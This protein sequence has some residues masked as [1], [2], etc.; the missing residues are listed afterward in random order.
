MNTF[1]F[2]LIQGARRTVRKVIAESSMQ[3]TLIGI[4][5]IPDTRESIS[6]FCKPLERTEA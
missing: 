3:A 4:R 2:T 1:A 6:I 5:M